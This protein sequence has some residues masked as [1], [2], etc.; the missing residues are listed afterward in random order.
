M[1]EKLVETLLAERGQ[2]YDETGEAIASYGRCIV[3][4][5]KEVELDQRVRVE[6]QEIRED[7]RGRMM[8][9]GIPAPV[10]YTERW[11]DNE[12]G[13]ASRVKIAIDWLL[14]ESEVEVIETRSFEDR[15]GRE[16]WHAD[17]QLTWGTDLEST[18]VEDYP[19]TVTA[20]EREVVKDGELSWGKTGE[21]RDDQVTSRSQVSQV[22]VYEG[23][24]W[25]SHRLDLTYQDELEIQVKVQ[26]DQHQIKSLTSS[27]QHFWLTWGDLPTWFQ[28]E[29]ASHYP[30]C[31][32]GRQRRD[33]QA[34]DGYAKCEL[35]RSEE[36]C[37]RCGKQAKVT[38]INSRLVCEDC[39]PY[40]EQEQLV[41]AHFT[42]EHRQT[43]ANE[44]R[45]LLAGQALEGELGEKVL[46]AG[47]GYVSSDYT[48]G[49]ILSR[50]KGYRWYYFTDEGIF[51][52]KFEPAALTVLQFL[53]QAAGN[54]LVEL[55]AW[56]EEGMRPSPRA[57]YYL[58]TQVDGVSDGVSPLITQDL[59][60]QVVTKLNADEPVLADWLRGS[61]SERIAALEAFRRAE[62]KFAED[63]YGSR[64]HKLYS[65]AR[66][67]LE[68]EGQ[69]YGAA[70]EAIEKALAEKVRQD[71][72]EDLL[73]QE[74]NTCPVCGSEWDFRS[75]GA[76]Y[77][78]EG[79]EALRTRGQYQNFEVKV[80]RVGKIEL[81]KLMAVYDD[82][83]NDYEL[84]L[85]IDE[86][87]LSVISDP[88]QIETRAYW[89]VPTE[90]ERELAE[91]LGTARAE[92]AHLES[93]LEEVG[94]FGRVLVTFREG[95]DPQ[96]QSQLQAMGSFTGSVENRKAETAYSEYTD[97]EALFVKR[98]HCSWLN[99]EPEAG[100]TWVATVA[101]QIGMTQGM[102]IIVVNPQVCVDRKSE[103]E[104]EV[105]RLEA[106]LMAERERESDL[107]EEALD[108]DG[109]PQT[110]MATAFREAMANAQE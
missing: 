17:L 34:E 62:E 41:A 89:R 83:H 16:T 32:C 69:D 72:L 100:Q 46:E 59:L 106:E 26:F 105:T 37:V 110:A 78:S 96:G 29:L 80:S 107:A 48:R 52:T 58:R 70:L 27:P 51:G 56:L 42:G 86:E 9:R 40:E 92:L 18:F 97:V 12:D 61:E 84:R 6:L 10:E 66:E 14:Q 54:S 81:V 20:L 73:A 36:V 4:L 43:I 103:L 22:E 95:V 91:K 64:T 2:R 50:W 60:K 49:Q 25:Y 76:H 39:Q 82:Y 74:Y 98:H 93:E 104:T 19:Y 53:S 28:D 109:E 44:A 21:R 88:S 1:T 24:R 101:F 3:F 87:N 63:L 71:V 31:S 67:A 90:R 7:R 79:Q 38:V 47:L 102:P 45:K 11:K 108:G 65:E 85:E 35:C 68:G 99:E 55:I 33:T 94:R 23:S 77:C 75:E 30:V 13:T 15:E 57:D 5:P 8:Y